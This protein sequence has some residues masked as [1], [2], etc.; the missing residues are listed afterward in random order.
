M[1]TVWVSAGAEAD[2]PVA[3]YVFDRCVVKTNGWVVGIDNVE[4]GTHNHHFPPN[5]VLEVEGDAKHER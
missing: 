1:T 5:R 3:E 4:N 2:S